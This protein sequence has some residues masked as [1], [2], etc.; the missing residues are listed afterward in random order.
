MPTW[1]QMSDCDASL[2]LSEGE[3]AGRLWGLLYKL[4]VQGACVCPEGACL[5][6][7]AMLSHCWEKLTGLPS[8]LFSCC[9]QSLLPI[10]GVLSGKFIFTPSTGSFYIEFLR[11]ELV[12]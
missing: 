9:L 10:V 1:E 3:M 8:Q 5:C 12:H 6:V 2:T 4:P 11:F 7:P